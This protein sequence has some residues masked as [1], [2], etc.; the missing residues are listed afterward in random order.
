MPGKRILLVEDER[1]VANMLGLALRGDGYDVETVDTATR[2]FAALRVPRHDLLVTDYRLPD[3][4]GLEVADRAA[5]EGIKTLIISGYLFMIPAHRA[6]AH[7]LMMK[8]MRAQELID[9]VKRLIS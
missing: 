5:A 6:R 2:A 3:G 9:T 1:D 8:P 7:E 4:N